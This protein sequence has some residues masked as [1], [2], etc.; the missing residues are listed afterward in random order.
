M[1][2][3]THQAEEDID[4]ICSASWACAEQ[5]K[6]CTGTPASCLSFLHLLSIF[7]GSSD[8][9]CVP[10]NS[11]DVG[12]IVGTAWQHLT[13]LK[14]HHPSQSQLPAGLLKFRCCFS[15][16]QLDD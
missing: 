12:S 16:L 13:S 1:Y 11:L 14:C 9:F 4:P 6:H 5:V 3:K 2:I 8:E 10:G 15:I 7:E